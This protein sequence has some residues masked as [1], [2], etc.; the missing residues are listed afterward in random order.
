MADTLVVAKLNYIQNFAS[1]TPAVYLWSAFFRVGGDDISI[2]A[3]GKMTGQAKIWFS[4]GS[5]D[6]ILNGD[7]L[8]YGA[9][10]ALDPSMHWSTSISPISTPFGPVDG[11]VGVLAALNVQSDTPNDAVEQ[12]HT[13]FNADVTAALATLLPTAIAANGQISAA[14]IQN[15]T[16]SIASDVQ[17]TIKSAIVT[18]PWQVFRGFEQWASQLLGGTDKNLGFDVFTSSVKRLDTYY[19]WAGTSTDEAG[20]AGTERL[21][22]KQPQGS[23]FGALIPPQ[24]GLGWILNLHLGKAPS[25]AH[26]TGSIAGSDNPPA[27]GPYGDLNKDPEKKKHHAILKQTDSTKQP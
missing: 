27:G 25:V 16:V 22:I 2:D 13:A 6:T 11:F 14:S 26:P 23:L 15:A 12:G 10:A 19:P 24:P 17:N 21:F 5:H 4:S 9:I 1:E 7:D 20:L 18:N 8:P 3:T